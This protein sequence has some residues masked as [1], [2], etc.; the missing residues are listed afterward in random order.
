LGDFFISV[1]DLAALLD[2][3][4]PPLLFDVRKPEAY[5]ESGWLIPSAREAPRGIDARVLEGGFAGWA[6]AGG[7]AVPATDLDGGTAQ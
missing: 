6:E 7:A 5:A 3:R 1:S 4:Q 2:S